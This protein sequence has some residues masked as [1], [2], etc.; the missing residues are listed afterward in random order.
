MR[1]VSA[2]ERERVAGVEAAREKTRSRNH[3]AREP[4]RLP[5]RPDAMCDVPK[6]FLRSALFGAIGKGKRRFLKRE[7]MAVMESLEV[8][9]RGERLDQGDLDVWEALLHAVRQQG[10]GARCRL[11]ACALLTLAGKTDTDK[12]RDALHASLDRLR[13]CAVMIKT[14]HYSYIGGLL[15][16]AAK[17]EETQEWVIEVDAQMRAL[18]DDDQ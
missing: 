13:A 7:P 15:A 17:D 14:G 1:A 4:L 18:F 12:N 2:L 16:W 5:L 9:F 3:A 6:G 11:T 8:S 10:L